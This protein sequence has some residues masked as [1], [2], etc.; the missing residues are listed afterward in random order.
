MLKNLSIKNYALIDDLNVDFN[1]GLTIITGETGA[2][3]SILI[4]ALSLLLGKRSDS[5]SINNLNKK[6]IVEATFDLSNYNLKNIF[7]DNNLD[8]DTDTI[9]RREIL[10]SGKSRAFV[11]DSPVVLNQLSSIS[12]YIIDIHSQHQNLD[13]VNID[14]QFDVI[15]SVSN[16]NKLLKE[17]KVKFLKYKNYKSELK[18][19]KDSKLELSK[20][21]DYNN[22]LL[23]EINN[24]NISDINLDDLEN[25]YKELSNFEDIKSDLNL[26]SSILNDNEH[27]IISL[28]SKLNLNLKDLS[29]KS[30]SFLSLY[31]RLNSIYIDLDDISKDIQASNDRLTNSPVELSEISDLLSKINN[32]LRKHSVDNLNDL[33]IIQSDLATKVS[34]SNNI[35]DEIQSLNS[36]IKTMESELLVLSKQ[37]NSNRVNVIPNLVKN[38][39]EI[40]GDLGMKSAQFL[41]EISPVE[42]FLFNGMDKLEF[43]FSA[44][45]GSDFK[46]LKH[47]ASGGEISRI[48]LAIKSIIANYKK[49]PTLMFDEI[50]TG[51]SGE[52]SNKIGDIM[53]EMSS[54][55]Q[56]FT[57]THLPQI[58]A[59][60]ESHFKVYKTE[61]DDSTT[62]NLIKLNNQD[63]IVEIAKMLEGDNISN[64]AVAH[65]KQLLN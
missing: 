47:S 19:I 58:A 31:N 39:K 38:L 55:M 12:Q 28:M 56:I 62:T 61:M 7:T 59:K 16:N 40:L 13:L 14:F 37:L 46:L 24:L 45:K 26:S 17:Y 60:G 6:C 34:K 32:V 35:D 29:S 25:S 42:D 20:A 27:G 22:H 9:I 23:D 65:A 51:V 49:L 21:F 53:Q 2:G 48:M 5:S 41:I 30:N 52:V 33:I 1:N 64:S 3:K 36:F 15:D 18:L 54:R 4:N 10:P 43:K 50:D 8:Y 11:N 57:I 63:R 44:N